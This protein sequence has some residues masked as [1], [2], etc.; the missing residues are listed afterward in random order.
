MQT[1]SHTHSYT[2][3]HTQ[4]RSRDEARGDRIAEQDETPR[5]AGTP[6]WWGASP[7]S[8]RSRDRGQ[9]SPLRVDSRSLVLPPSPVR[10]DTP[11]V[12]S[13]PPAVGGAGTCHGSCARPSGPHAASQ[14][15][16]CGGARFPEIRSDRPLHP[17]G[18]YGAL[19]GSDTPCCG[20]GGNQGRGAPAGRK[21]WPP[22]RQEKRRQ[23][24]SPRRTPPRGR[25]WQGGKTHCGDSHR[26]GAARS[27]SSGGWPLRANPGGP[28]RERKPLLGSDQPAPRPAGTRR[29]RPAGRWPWGQEVGR[30]QRATCAPVLLE[31]APSVTEEGHCPAMQGRPGMSSRFTRRNGAFP[32]RK[33][34]LCPRR[35]PLWGGNELILPMGRTC[36]RGG[37]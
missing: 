36:H 19:R 37:A 14:P 4:L 13:G 11:W 27:V 21:R 12:S 29:S 6:R 28:A 17:S 18:G 16:S 3:T 34:M 22:C 33:R 7:P 1:H 32:L 31:G 23:T 30:E 8:P 25:P 20:Q 26:E 15:L 2:L 35:R 24:G 9:A 5:A 10:P